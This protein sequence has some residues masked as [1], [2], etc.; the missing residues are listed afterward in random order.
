VGFFSTYREI[1]RTLAENKR[2]RERVA[3]LEKRLDEKTELL[4][5]RDFLWADRLLVRNE[6]YPI[7]DEAVAK[8]INRPVSVPFDPRAEQNAYLE[9]KRREIYEDAREA[10]RTEAEAERFYRQRE[11]FFIEDFETQT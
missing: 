2:L 11:P 10:G 6:S 9:A 1:K 5:E 8:V 3:F 4:L 7:A